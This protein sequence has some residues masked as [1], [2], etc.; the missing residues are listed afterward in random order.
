[1]KPRKLVLNAFGPFCKKVEI[2]FDEFGESGLF[3]LTGDTGA[4]KTTIFDAISY[5]L[6]G[7]ASGENRTPDCFRSDYAEGEDK[8][9]V[10]LTFLHKAKSYQVTRNP[11]YERSKLKSTGTTMEKA[12]AT[13][14]MPDGSIIAGSSKVT[15]AIIDLLGIDW[16]QYKQIA[17][18]AQGEFLQLLTADSN[19][20]GTIFRKVFGT[21]IFEEI[22]KKL[23]FMSNNLKYRC[24]D[25]DKSI[26]QFLKGINCDNEDTSSSVINEWKSKPDINQVDNILEMLTNLIEKDV[27]LFEQEQGVNHTISEEIKKK[28]AEYT[29]AQKINQAFLEL[30]QAKEQHQVLLSH[31][32]EMKRIENLIQEG[33]KAFYTV[34]PAE[35]SYQRIRLELQKLKAAIELQQQEEEKITKE[36]SELKVIWEEKEATCPEINELNIR[37][38]RQEDDRIKYDAVEE[39]KAKYKKAFV[40]KEQL[41]QELKNLEEQNKI[42][43]AKRE[44][45]TREQDSYCNV[46]RDLV[47]YSNQLEQKRKSI[48][49]YK[50][51]LAQNGKLIS[52]KALLE[53][54]Q[55]E[56]TQVQLQYN[57]QNEQ[58][59]K[60]EHQFLREQAGIIAGN[61]VEG[62]PCPVCGSKE[63]PQKALL[64]NEAPS[65]EQLKQAGTKRE[66]LQN[67][68]AEASSNCRNQITKIQLFQSQLKKEIAEALEEFKIEELKIEEFKADK[69]IITELKITGLQME[70]L[71]SFDNIPVQ[72]KQ[73]LEEEERAA[74]EL[75]KKVH[76]LQEKLQQKEQCAIRLQKISE[77]LEQKEKLYQEK[78]EGK[79][80]VVNQLS[81]LEGQLTTLRGDLLYS[82]K[83]EAEQAL[84]TDHRKY[85]ELQEALHQAEVNFRTGETRLGKLKA[86]LADNEMKQ[87]EKEKEEKEEKEKWKAKLEACGFADYE[88]YKASLMTE[89][90][91]EEN[92]H[93]LDAYHKSRSTVEQNLKRLTQETLGKEKLELTALSKEQE[94]LDLQKQESE[95]RLQNIYSRRKVNEEILKNTCGTYQEQESLRKEFLLVNEL[96]KTA[97]GE[98]AG[99][100]KIAFEQYVQAFYFNSIINEAN[101]RLYKMSNSQFALMRK[102]DPTNLR[103]SAGLDLEVMDYYTGKARSIKSLSGGE[104]FKAALSLAL[105][106]SDVIQNFAGGI[107]VDAMFIDEGFG[108]LD[109][110][111]LEQA[112]ETLNTLTMGNRYVGIISHV[113][114]LKERIEK[115]IVITKKLDG[116][117][118]TLIK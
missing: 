27:L 78:I 109:S 63:H 12:D 24:E 89:E 69:L 79:G 70:E 64:T 11:A 117:N 102:E 58:Y 67:K 30:E 29:S 56:F 32:T 21:Q 23:K 107:Q 103:S 46:D 44:E 53:Q 8:T 40:S 15:T 31:E 61:L 86:V 36:L 50:D 77:E 47:D 82:T 38:K 118:L 41:E 49:K 7:N 87:G 25:L 20:R 5:A 97:N 94:E 26:L 91:L 37:I 18:I 33:R 116:S 92:Q 48:A 99:K 106:L 6:F 2:P 39:L 81:M 83:D 22:Q 112:I 16:R 100:A 113:S 35:E 105:G 98:L 14:I 85:T 66:E 68:M 71:D 57:S 1:M 84:I 28:A 55:I 17:M 90:E 9:F 108:S 34:R 88:Q 54:L 73:R 65:E 51:I 59:L 104:S 80:V 62:Q 72:V 4:G 110:N 76:N 13:L 96:S 45:K 52:E 43:A 93:R 111:S 114:E 10:E 3:L 42:L 115:K 75:Q 101:K 95:V 19:E 74:N 60:L